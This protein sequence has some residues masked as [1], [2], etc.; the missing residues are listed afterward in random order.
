MTG[1]LLDT[2]VVSEFK[3]L[4]PDSGVELWL[5]QVDPTAV[6][7]SS[8]TIGELWYGVE[9][10]SDR[11]KRAELEHWLVSGLLVNFSGR[12]LS[13]DADAAAEWGRLR[14]LA[15]GNGKSLPVVDGMLAAIARRYGLM[16][17]TRNERDFASTKIPTLNPWSN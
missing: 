16:L 2:C 4:R 13:L 3:K 10:L 8:I 6:F 5:S 9:R 1:F 15:V 7:I 14:A 11:R 12:V 17:V